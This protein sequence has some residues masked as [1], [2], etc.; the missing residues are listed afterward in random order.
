MVRVILSLAVLALCLAA[1][2]LTADR[3]ELHPAG[4]T[5]TLTGL[6]RDGYRFLVV[7]AAIPG[8]QP[9]RCQARLLDAAGA[10]LDEAALMV[11][12]RSSAQVDFAARSTPGRAVDAQVSC[13][14][15]F[16]A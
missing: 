3:L 15:T 16:H 9:A 6:E 12:A 2:L 8:K 7:G 5:A 14:R 11:P 1:P 4:D 10:V 13:D